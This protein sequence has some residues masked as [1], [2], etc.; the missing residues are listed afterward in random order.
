MSP[1]WCIVAATDFQPSGTSK[2]D[3][4]STS[5]KAADK[6]NGLSNTGKIAVG[7]SFAGV[8]VVAVATLSF[9]CIKQRRVGRQERLLAD[10][11]FEKG[12]AELMAF[13][14]QMAANQ[15]QKQA[16]YSQREIYQ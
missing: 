13:R 7:S 16:Y 2:L 8:L 11:E 9:C 10:A 14:A 12:A 3:L 1:E 4:E 6:W 15:S 5:Q